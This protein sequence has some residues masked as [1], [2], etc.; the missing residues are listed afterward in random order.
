MDVFNDTI[1]QFIKENG[2][3]KAQDRILVACSGGV[4]SI[5]LLHFLAVHREKLAIEVAAIHVDHMLR[6]KESALEGDLVSDLCKRLTIPFYSGQG[7][8]T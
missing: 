6:G 4:D 7:T 5:A 2:L 3:I 8:G 1:L